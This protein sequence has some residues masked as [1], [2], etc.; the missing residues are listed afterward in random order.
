MSRKFKIPTRYYDTRTIYKHREFELQPGVTVLIGCNGCGKTTLLYHVK[1]SLDDDKIPVMLYNNLSEGGN[2]SMSSLVF[3]GDM[4]KLA[5]LACSSEGESIAINLGSQAEKIIYL[6]NNGRRKKSD[7]EEAF[8]KIEGLKEELP[9][10]NE[11]WLLFDAID[12]GLSIDQVNDVKNYVLHP[13]ID[14]VKDKEIYIVVTANEYEMCIGE[15]CF[16]VAE[17]K[18][19]EINSYEDYKR[20]ILKTRKYKDKMLA[21]YYKRLEE[22]EKKQSSK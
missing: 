18:Y 10:S 6:V 4:D 13:V 20:E 19:V 8:M 3:T 2:H 5:L 11:R 15:K 14:Q 7:L 12:S 17:G 9:V 1:E 21:S 16:N 22:K